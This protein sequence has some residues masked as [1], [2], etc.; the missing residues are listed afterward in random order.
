MF[1]VGTT[2]SA[3]MEAPLMSV[4][5]VLGYTKQQCC[6]LLP[7]VQT[8][9]GMDVEVQGYLNMLARFFQDEEIEEV[10]DE[11]DM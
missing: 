10:E 11:S 1:S 4:M 7:E 2:G 8:K 9:H 6:P 3:D 5:G